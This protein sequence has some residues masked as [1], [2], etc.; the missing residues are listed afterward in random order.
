MKV[1]WFFNILMW[2][3]YL[4]LHK[5][6]DSQLVKDVCA[7][8]P[9]AKNAT[10]IMTILMNLRDHSLEDITKSLPQNACGCAMW[11]CLDSLKLPSESTRVLVFWKISWGGGSSFGLAQLLSHISNCWRLY[12]MQCSTS[13]LNCSR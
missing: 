5:S 6:C 8:L 2:K 12:I 10:V 1:V 4:C 11:Q 9:G 3:W 13:L 7:S